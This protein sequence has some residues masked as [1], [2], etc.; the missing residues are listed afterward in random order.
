MQVAVNEFTDDVSA[1]RGRTGPQ[2][3][4]CIAHGDVLE[5]ELLAEERFC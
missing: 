3:S 2:R 1:G 5:A 4:R